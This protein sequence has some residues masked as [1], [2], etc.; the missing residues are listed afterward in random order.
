MSQLILQTMFSWSNLV[1]CCH[2]YMCE[3]QSMS[4]YIPF[5]SINTIGLH[6]PFLCSSFH[7]VFF[8][9]F[10]Q[11]SIYRFFSICVTS[12]TVI[13]VCF[14]FALLSG[15]S[16]VMSL[17]SY[18]QNVSHSQMVH[19]WTAMAFLL[20][21]FCVDILCTLTA[22][23]RLWF[24]F[25]CCCCCCLDCLYWLLYTILYSAK[26]ANQNGEAY[27]LCV[28]NGRIKCIAFFLDAMLCSVQLSVFSFMA[29]AISEKVKYKKKKELEKRNENKTPYKHTHTQ[30]N[31]I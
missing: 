9:S 27:T 29:L 26:Q 16:S 22:L 28:F 21:Q 12:G 8:S 13:S 2:W 4:Q 15:S 3:N 31:K 1:Y 25:G 5:C 30:V 20:C 17:I 7:L 19:F 11:L 23:I 6:Y 10:I 14:G 24:N 18:V